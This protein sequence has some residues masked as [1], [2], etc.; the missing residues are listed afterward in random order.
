[1]HSDWL[2]LHLLA[3]KHCHGARTRACVML[4]EAVC[5]A[6]AVLSALCGGIAALVMHERAASARNRACQHR[7]VLTRSAHARTAA[8]LAVACNSTRTTQHVHG[9]ACSRCD[10]ATYCTRQR[11][12]R[13]S[14]LAARTKR[15]WSQHHKARTQLP[16]EYRTGHTHT[17]RPLIRFRVAC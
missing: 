7:L 1:M 15:C 13:Q 16:E 9:V 5:R 14:S 2:R 10:A 11:A 8:T 4:H 6:R 12:Q 3:P 17:S